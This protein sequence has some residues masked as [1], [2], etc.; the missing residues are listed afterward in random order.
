MYECIAIDEPNWLARL[1]HVVRE[2]LTGQPN[3]SI[4]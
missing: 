4:Q 1:S 3:Q 2:I